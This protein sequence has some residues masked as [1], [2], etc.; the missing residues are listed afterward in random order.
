[1]NKKDLI[2][3][4]SIAILM[5]SASL[6]FCQSFDDNV[7]P[8][9]LCWSQN[10]SLREEHFKSESIPNEAVENSSIA[11]LS[12]LS[13]EIFPVSRCGEISF[14]IY[15]LFNMD[16]SWIS[17]NAINISDLL[18]HEKLHF[19]IAEIY[20]RILRKK[21]AGYLRECNYD[22][23]RVN[24]IINEVSLEKEK[25]QEL[26]DKETNLG[27]DLAKQQQW[28]NDIKYKLENLKNYSLN[29]EFDC[30]PAY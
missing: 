5:L 2:V 14:A 28:E 22:E 4:L 8:K 27:L 7:K 6:V 25:L 9:Y 21:L 19:D 15:N 17:K 18:I 11:A 10:L 12:S 20:A 30:P 23:N 13:V 16:S 24:I 29:S 26:F 1:M 3:V